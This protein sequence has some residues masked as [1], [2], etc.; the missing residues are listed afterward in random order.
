MPV[1]Q[2]DKSRDGFKNRDSPVALQEQKEIFLLP[3][4][5]VSNLLHSDIHVLLS[6]TGKS[7][8]FLG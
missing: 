5:Q 6:E 1:I 3:T 8:N 2:P 7:R 4:I